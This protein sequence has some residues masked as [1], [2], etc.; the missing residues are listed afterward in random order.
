LIPLR[1]QEVIRQRFGQEQASRVRIDYFSQ[2]QTKIIIPGRQDCVHCEDVRAMLEELSHLSPRIS[3]TVH[4][5]S[6]DTKAAAELGVDK[7]PGIAIR[8]QANRTVRFSG[9]PAGAQFP[10]FI[11]TIIDASQ[12]SVELKPETARQLKKLKDDVTVQVFVTPAC[13]HSP[14]LARTALKLGLFSNRLK[15][16]VVEVSEYPALAERLGIRATPVT[17]INERLL[18]PGAL[19]EAALLRA[20]SKVLES[21]PLVTS[22]FEPGPATPLPAPQQQAQARPATTAG[23]IILPR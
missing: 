5:L 13:R 18:I 15:V 23:G 16:E 19:D 10:G 14:Q 7:V 3:L 12:A 6:D 20:I 8:G 9:I 17:F 22:D 2:R 4:E 11:D 21:K 1:E